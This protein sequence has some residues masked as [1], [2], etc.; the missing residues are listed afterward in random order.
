M[1]H[2]ESSYRRFLEGDKN[3]FDHVFA[4]YYDSLTF[5]ANRYVENVHDAEDIAI[6]TLLEL[7]LHPKRYNFRT[8]LKAYLF[9]IA[10]NKSLNFLRDHRKDTVLP[11]DVEG[12]LADNRSLAEEL[13]KKEEHRALNQALDT[14]PADLRA[15]ITWC[16]SRSCLMNKPQG[17]WG[18]AKSR[19]T[20]CCIAPKRSCGTHWERK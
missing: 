13:I 14:L 9:A 12:E 16:T 19:S 17:S 6:N 7:L 15:A 4:L 20:T 10:R 2:G 5:F 11:E 3:A 18:R 1:D 8:P